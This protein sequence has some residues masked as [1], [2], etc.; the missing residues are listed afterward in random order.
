MPLCPNPENSSNS[1]LMIQ[2]QCLMSG[3][4]AHAVAKATVTD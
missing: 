3:W 4:T 2:T 1:V